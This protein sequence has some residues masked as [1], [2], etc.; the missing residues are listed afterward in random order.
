MSGEILE[1]YD[2]HSP[3][4]HEEIPN[5]RKRCRWQ[6]NSGPIEKAVKEFVKWLMAYVQCCSQ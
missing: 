3:P 4:K 5:S 2:K 1:A 6:P